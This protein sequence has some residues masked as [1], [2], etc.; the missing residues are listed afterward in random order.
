[1][2]DTTGYHSAT[3]ETDRVRGFTGAPIRH[4]ASAIAA[5]AV[6]IGCATP[7]PGEKESGADPEASVR[8][9]KLAFAKAGTAVKVASK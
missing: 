2:R 4:L 3:D 7:R 1:M 8:M 5:A 9:T 6:V